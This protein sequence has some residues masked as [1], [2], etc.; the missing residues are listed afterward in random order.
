MLIDKAKP[1]FFE[2]NHKLQL[3]NKAIYLLYS[4]Y[5]PKR[6]DESLKIC[7]GYLQH[8]DDFDFSFLKCIIFIELANGFDQQKKSFYISKI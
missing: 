7:D 4:Y 1:E 2:G 8:V 5:N 6:F 3:Y